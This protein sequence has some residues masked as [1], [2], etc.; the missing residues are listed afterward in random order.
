[1]L[2]EHD[3]VDP[4]APSRKPSMRPPGPPPTMQQEVEVLGFAMSRADARGP[5]RQLARARAPSF[6]RTYTLR[7]PSIAGA[8][9]LKCNHRMPDEGAR[10]RRFATVPDHLPTVE[11]RGISTERGTQSSSF[12]HRRRRARTARALAHHNRDWLSRRLDGPATRSLMMRSTDVTSF[13][14]ALAEAPNLLEELRYAEID[15]D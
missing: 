3:D 14:P 12:R 13:P 15:N 11:T 9:R 2:L 7:S 10:S 5:G 8:T 6:R 1:M 4:G